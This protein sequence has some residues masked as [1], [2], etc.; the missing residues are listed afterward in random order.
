MRRAFADRRGFDLIA[1]EVR[2]SP[3]EGQHPVGYAASA[4]C[5]DDGGSG[6]WQ[7]ADPSGAGGGFAESNDLLVLGGEAGQSL[8]AEAR[9]LVDR[10]LRL[11]QPLLEL[12]VLCFEAGDVGFAVV[13]DVSGLLQ[14]LETS[15]EFGAEVCV[16]AGAV[17]GGAVDG[18]F[19]GEGLDVALSAGRISP[20]RR[21]RRT[22]ERTPTMCVSPATCRLLLACLTKLLIASPLSKWLMG[23]LACKDA[24][25]YASSIDSS[26]AVMIALATCSMIH[27]CRLGRSGSSLCLVAFTAGLP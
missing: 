27:Q 18:C 22:P 17:E 1:G 7:A 4:A 13:G 12:G 24:V 15:L 5:P 3:C 11:G 19:A 2:L 6:W 26:A 16:G 9:E 10:P 23:D 21:C 25:V 8:G 14:G 20:R